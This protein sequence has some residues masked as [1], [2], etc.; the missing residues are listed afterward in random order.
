MIGIINKRAPNNY[1]NSKVGITLLLMIIV[2]LGA[3][4]RLYKLGSNDLW[5][6]EALSVLSADKIE[7]VYSLPDV[8]VPYD[9]LALEEREARFIHFKTV[10]PQP[11]LY[12]LILK[13]AM[14]CLGKSALSLRL[15]SVFFSILS[16]L[17]MYKV[18]AEI[19]NK[20]NGIYAA[21]LIAISPIHIWYAQEA[22][23]YSLSVFLMLLSVYL[24]LRALEREGVKYWLGFIVSS[25][26]LIYT[27]YIGLV[28]LIAIW[29][30]FGIKKYRA[31]LK[32]CI[33]ASV[34]IILLFLPCIH[35][36]WQH[37]LFVKEA[38]W[39]ARPSL[40]S[41]M[42]TF[43][44]FN[45]GYS[46]FHFVFLP[47]MILFFALAFLGF[48]S[49]NKKAKMFLL[50]F[51]FFP[52]LFIFVVSQRVPIYL[53]RQLIIFSP[54]YYLAVAKGISCIR[55]NVI[56]VSLVC[57]ILVFI[58]SSIYNYFSNQMPILPTI[59]HQGSYVKKPFEPAIKYI[60]DNWQEGD[61]L[62]YSHIS[63]KPSFLYYQQR[64]D[65][66]KQNDKNNSIYKRMWLVSSSW[67]RD[68][69]LGPGVQ[70]LRERL[71]EQHE[72][73]DSVEFDGIFID[74]YTAED[75]G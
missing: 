63:V 64:Y 1:M 60:E 31:S 16:I 17:V 69:I 9:N 49:I 30:L 7:K 51:L 35:I 28:I 39:L 48:F 54:F 23:Q 33:V 53:D 52:I 67:S 14:S 43:K 75:N 6:D 45:I 58:A 61:T 70:L 65:N 29:P 8:D 56:R 37:F 19:S 55:H 57:L 18:G 11:F 32:K 36:F 3:S 38:F 44:N 26:L 59:Y 20:K 2:L 34:V 27:N 73:V 40:Y 10:D 24:L 71:K 62:V 74:L 22:R 13:C 68:G 21:F 12:Y 72:K 66:L 46:N 50:M 4:L 15:V 5:F 41:V 47:S 42:I 25:I